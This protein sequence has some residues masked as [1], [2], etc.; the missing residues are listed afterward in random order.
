MIFARRSLAWLWKNLSQCT[1]L[2][3][4]KMFQIGNFRVNGKVILSQFGTPNV[5][6][7][8]LSASFPL[9]SNLASDPEA[10]HRVSLRR[11]RGLSL[12][13]EQFDLAFFKVWTA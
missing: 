11:W 2:V 5:A 1:G 12:E 6:R 3:A 9:C 10:R 8:R 7:L 13:P 4:F